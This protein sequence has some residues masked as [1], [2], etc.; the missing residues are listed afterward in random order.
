MKTLFSWL[1][2]G[3]RE[4]DVRSD[5]FRYVQIANALALL[6]ALLSFMVTV[7]LYLIFGWVLSVPLALGSGLFFLGMVAMNRFGQH[8][9]G[10][11]GISLF[12]PLYAL[13]VSILVKQGEAYVEEPEYFD[14]RLIILSASLLPVL[15]FRY[16]EWRMWAAGLA[17][18]FAILLGYDV[19]HDWFGVG[20]YQT[21]HTASN[22]A[23]ARALFPI[24]YLLLTGSFLYYKRQLEKAEGVLHQNNLELA[25]LYK[26]I[27]SQNEEIQAQAEDLAQSQN[28]LQE[29]YQQISQH[30][31]ALTNENTLLYQHLREQ[32]TILESSNAELHK[33]LDELEQFS[34]TLSHNLRGPVAS[35]LGLTALFDVQQGEPVNP[36]LVQHIKTTAQRLDDVIQDL[37]KVLQ[38]REGNKPFEEVDLPQLVNHV[39]LALQ[40]AGEDQ[41]A[42]ID[43]DLNVTSVYCIKSYLHSIL[44][45]LISNALKYCDPLRPSK[46]AVHA[47]QEGQE[48]LLEVADNG[49][50]IDLERHGRQ[51]F[52]MYHRF[53][54]RR[55]GRG[56]G[57]YLARV[58]A[59]AMEG[60]IEVQ[61]EV[62]KGTS[63]QIWLPLRRPE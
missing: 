23:F 29:A 17:I 40:D 43:L 2:Y 35:L 28:K 32:N 4:Q 8:R 49:I 53:S 34:Y 63:F 26:E 10:R 12:V 25:D 31:T 9:L 18:S 37:A 62:G 39:L 30:N 27:Q 6:L 14:T 61:S 19:V 55:E 46:V 11:I 42:T 58:Q 59:E 3:E 50:G 33:R 7:A 36:E 44:Y 48:L 20:Y 1:T 56:L 38:M 54:V 45:N 21:G 15:L 13:L 51:L 24:T 52:K 60:H 16:Q 47:R 22:Y 57:L 5:D 41:D